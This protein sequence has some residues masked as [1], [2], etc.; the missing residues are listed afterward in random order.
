MT[1]NKD[2]LDITTEDCK[3][4]KVEFAPGCFDSF[5]GS[6]E[7][8][9]DLMAEIHRMVETGELF[10]KGVAVDLDELSED[11]DFVKAMAASAKKTLQ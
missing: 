3:T 10:E 8:L 7:E 2:P 6:Q 11:E 5:E 1:K 4:I 9:N